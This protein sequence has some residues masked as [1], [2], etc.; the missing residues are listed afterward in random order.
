MAQ[1]T[2]TANV[3]KGST[4]LST[5][6]ANFNVGTSAD[7]IMSKTTDKPQT[8][9]YVSGDLITFTININ[10]NGNSSFTGLS[11][12]DL[13]PPQVTVTTVTSTIDGST[14]GTVT[15]GTPGPTGTSVTVTGT[16]SVVKLDSTKTWIVTINGTIV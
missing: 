3:K 4:Q 12:S 5:A 8:E 9:Y 11:F 16:G 15:I 10:N 6:A 7:I 13:V 2:N 1:Y 14:V